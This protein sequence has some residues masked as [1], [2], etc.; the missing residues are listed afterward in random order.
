MSLRRR[1]GSAYSNAKIKDRLPRTLP[2]HV[3]EFELFES[4]DLFVECLELVVCDVERPER[5][6]LVPSDGCFPRVLAPVVIVVVSR[7]DSKVEIER[8]SMVERL[9]FRRVK[10]R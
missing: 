7:G 9:S 8:A 1:L 6:L 10:R 3:E 2:T 5:F 4:A